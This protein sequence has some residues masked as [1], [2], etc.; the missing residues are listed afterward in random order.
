MMKYE[1]HITFSSGHFLSEHLPEDWHKWDEEKLYK[2][3]EDHVVEFLEGYDGK[4]IM[5][6][7]DGTA[8]ATH[9]Y[10]TLAKTIR[11]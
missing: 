1:E 4:Y 9:S 3:C 6:L 8:H 7:I 5:D 11:G 2:F 10:V